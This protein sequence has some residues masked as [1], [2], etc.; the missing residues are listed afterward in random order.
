M[1]KSKNRNNHAFELSVV[2]SYAIT[3]QIPISFI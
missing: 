1:Q 3:Y 2:I